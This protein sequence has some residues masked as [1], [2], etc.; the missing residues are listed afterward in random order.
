[1]KR[2]PRQICLAK[3]SPAC[4]IVRNSERVFFKP[5]SVYV[6]IG[7]GE[8]YQQKLIETV[9]Y[10]W[11]LAV[12]GPEYDQNMVLKRKLENQ[13]RIGPIGFFCVVHRPDRGHTFCIW[14]SC[15]NKQFSF[16]PEIFLHIVRAILT[17]RK[18]SKLSVTCQGV[19]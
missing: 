17:S 1:M 11:N 3:P 10:V 8:G 12:L 18:Q 13:S 14:G 19:I 2:S 15:C 5:V 7:R 6:C 4:R 16:S 9:L